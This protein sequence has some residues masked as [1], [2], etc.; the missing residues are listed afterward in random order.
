MTTGRTTE[1]PVRPRRGPPDAA[2]RR[3]ALDGLPEHDRPTDVPTGDA[4]TLS[5]SLFARLCELDEGTPEHAYVRNTLIELNLSLV[6]FAA[7]RFRG[8]PEPREDIVQVGTIGLIKAIDRFD[9]DRGVDFSTF[10]LPTIVGEMKRFFRDTGWAVH[11]PRRLQELR[12]GLAKAAEA[13]EQ[14]G[15]HR[16]RRSELAERLHLTEGEVAEA[17]LAAN[18]YAVRSLDAPVDGEDDEVRALRGTTGRRTARTEPAY[19]LIDNLQALAPLVARLDERDRKILS[20]RF[21]DELTQAQ[22][23][24]RLGLSQMHVSRLLTR[25]L[26]E[27]RDGLLPEEEAE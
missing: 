5:V 9:P 1:A 18:A 26:G 20:L 7:R 6:K 10:A 23:G 15:G 8:R 27:L 17:Q 14:D 21:G 19:E 11:V 16:P 2:T 24:E 22:I 3:R 4:T 13:L 12:I 25:L